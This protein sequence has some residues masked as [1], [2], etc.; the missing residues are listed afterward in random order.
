LKAE[1]TTIIIVTHKPSL[2]THVD[3]MLVLNNGQV[4]MFGPREAVFKQFMGP[5]HAPGMAVAG[6]PAARQK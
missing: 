6:K 5:T 3:K 1:G 4:A 2:L